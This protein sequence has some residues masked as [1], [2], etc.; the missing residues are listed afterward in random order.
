MTVYVYQSALLCES[1][2]LITRKRLDVIDGPIAAKSDW[3]PQGPIED[4]GG[5]ADSPQH[6]DRCHVFLENPLTEDGRDF[7]RRARRE[8]PANQRVREWRA[9]YFPRLT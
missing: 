1:C 6:C 3:Y 4:G 2:A 7:V 5:E 9:F 8:A